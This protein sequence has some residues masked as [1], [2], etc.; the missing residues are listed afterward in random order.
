MIFID[1]NMQIHDFLAKINKNHRFRTKS[2]PE[3]ID[4]WQNIIGKS[5]IRMFWPI[6]TNRIAP[7]PQKSSWSIFR[8]V[9]DF[10]C[11]ISFFA[12]FSTFWYRSL[13]V[14]SRF[15][16][17]DHAVNPTDRRHGEVRGNLKLARCYRLLQRPQTVIFGRSGDTAMRD[18]S[19]PACYASRLFTDETIPKLPYHTA[20][21]EWS[22]NFEARRSRPS[23]ISR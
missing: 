14:F 9:F 15:R 19:V 2:A 23:S 8:V 21:T 6:K 13:K 4:Y 22:L 18:Y 17:I 20:D 7:K 11:K 16:Q 1:Q 10:S 5:W 12:H 3:F